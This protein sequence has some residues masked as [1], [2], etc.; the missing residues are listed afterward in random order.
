MR[1]AELKW[2]YLKYRINGKSNTEAVL[3]LIR[4]L[5]G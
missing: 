2:I 1:A 4:Y 3:E 5:C